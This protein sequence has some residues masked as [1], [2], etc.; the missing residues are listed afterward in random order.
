MFPPNFIVVERNGIDLEINSKK[1]LLEVLGKYL[2]TA[3]P[4]ATGEEIFSRLL[5]RERLGSTGLGLGIALPHARLRRADQPVGAF[6]RLTK[7]I[8]FNAIDDEPIDLAFALVVPEAATEAHLQ[9]LAKLAG[10]FGDEGLRTRLRTAPD[11][12]ATL[13][14]LLEAE[15]LAAGV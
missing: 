1:R 10:V 9:L 15:S 14:L 4:S 11:A 13:R 7:G 3:V 5:D 12:D 2:A 8:D 6:V